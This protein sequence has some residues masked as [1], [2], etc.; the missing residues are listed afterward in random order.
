MMDAMNEIKRNT[1]RSLMSHREQR[2][3]VYWIRRIK[4]TWLNNLRGKRGICMSI[5][6]YAERE[7]LEIEDLKGGL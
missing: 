7:E 1:N 3:H 6:V 4:T 5:A 2:M